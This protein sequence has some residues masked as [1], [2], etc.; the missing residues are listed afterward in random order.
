MSKLWCMGSLKNKQFP[1][2]AIH[3][4]PL[5]SYLAKVDKKN[6]LFSYGGFWVI[7]MKRSSQLQQ[8]IKVE[9]WHTSMIDRLL[10]SDQSI[11]INKRT[12][13]FET[14]SPVASIQPHTDDLSAISTFSQSCWSVTGR[15]EC[16]HLLFDLA[17]L[18]L[19]KNSDQLSIFGKKSR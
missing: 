18:S 16:T 6:R 2:P 12:T 3:P 19:S 7:F 15:F 5:M 10:Q 17:A 9:L 4:H 1:R 8:V 11:S 14:C 13:N